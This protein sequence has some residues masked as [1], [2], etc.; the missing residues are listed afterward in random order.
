MSG[1]EL[2]DA[3]VARAVAVPLRREILDLIV[4]SDHSVTVAE[5]TAQLG[6]HHNAVRQ[7]LAQLAAAG[8]TE[9]THEVRARKGRPRLL[10]TAARR[11]DPYARL[12][13]MLLDARRFGDSPR[14]VG[15]RAGRA[16][17]AEALDVA[18]DGRGPPEALVVLEA[19]ARRQGFAPRRVG[20]GRHVE[21]VL[22]ACPL[23]D[24]AMQDAATVCALHRGLAEGIVER[25]GGVRVDA[26]VANDPRRAGCRVRLEATA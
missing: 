17:A 2:P 21:L 7:H 4:A 20:R 5:L 19:D 16:E 10:Y 9:V 13:H 1:G 8:L 11:P 25:V 3:T 18:R 15:R 26:F 12:A 23:A 24:A 14:Q 6:C 22:D